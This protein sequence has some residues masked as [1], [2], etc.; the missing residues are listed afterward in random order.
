MWK[1]GR[2]R[3]AGHGIADLEDRESGEKGSG[4]VHFRHDLIK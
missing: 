1:V 4:T 2:E 3:Q